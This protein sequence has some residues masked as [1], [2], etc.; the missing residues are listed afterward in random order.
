MVTNELSLLM[1]RKFVSLIVQR[2][3]KALEEAPDE[4][5]HYRDPSGVVMP[6][7]VSLLHSLMELEPHFK[8]PLLD[9]LPAVTQAREKIL[10]S[11][12]VEMQKL[13]LQPGREIS[14]APNKNFD[15][16]IESA[17]KVP[18][19]NRREDL[20]ATAVLSDKSNSQRLE[21]L[22][23]V[24]EKVSN[25]NIR[26]HVM[27]HIY[28]RRALVSINSRNFE[29]AEKLIA[30]VKGHEQRAYLQTEIAKTL[31]DNHEREAYASEVLDQAIS[32]AK[33]AGATIFAARTLLTASSLYTKIDLSRS[34][35]VLTDAI[36]YINKI[37]NLDFVR[38]DQ[39][40]E[41]MV[42]RPGRRGHY[43]IRFYMPGLDPQ[44]VLGQ[45]AKIDFDTALSQRNALS[46]KLQRALS[47]LALADVCLQQAQK[48]LKE[49]PKGPQIRSLALS[50]SSS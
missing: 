9:L 23:E 45:M 43:R 24:I 39:A 47:A 10:V 41:N 33:K 5:D 1:Q 8:G 6:P 38:D 22:I 28:F 44:T 30:R 11:L 46:D 26:E 48:Q 4:S 13:L 20:I 35:A 49:S 7:T 17:L 19:V 15:E 21:K 31:L 34:I 18:D 12:S 37:E 40:K 36:N 42:P 50:Q 16:E 3:Q 2:A 14:V 27:E 29:E 32:E 25:S